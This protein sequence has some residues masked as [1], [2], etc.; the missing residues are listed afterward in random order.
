MSTFILDFEG[1]Y[2][3]EDAKFYIQEFAYYEID[4]NECKN[5]FLS[6]P[7][8]FDYNK[9]DHIYK[10]INHILPNYGTTKFNKIV[11]F[12]QQNAIFFV[13]GDLKFNF[14]KKLTKS[15]VINLKQFMCPKLTLLSTNSEIKCSFIRHYS[16][17][18]CALNKVVKLAAWF[19]E[20]KI[21]NKLLI[22]LLNKYF[23]IKE[24]N[25]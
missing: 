22:V 15:H 12:L 20:N 18:N 1:L 4:T 7:A 14:L 23:G 17:S 11:Q 3:K 2:N 6:M 25:N 10:N 21:S 13:K 24:S 19:K 8:N 9:H 16:I 5:Y